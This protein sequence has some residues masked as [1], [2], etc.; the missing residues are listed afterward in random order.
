MKILKPLVHSREFWCQACDPEKAMTF[1]ELTE[2][3][4]TAHQLTERISGKREGVLYVDMAHGQYHNT[5]E[6]TLIGGL[7]ITESRKG[8]RK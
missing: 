1:A 8:E 5:F 2:H 3:L 7:K 6:W 4:K